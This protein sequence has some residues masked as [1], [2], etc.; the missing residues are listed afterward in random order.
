MPNLKQYLTT[1]YTIV[2][3]DISPEACAPFGYLHGEK[4]RTP[5]GV[6]ATVI[7]VELPSYNGLSYNKLWYSKDGDGGRVCHWCRGHNKKDFDA[8]GFRPLTT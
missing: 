3:L 8:E 1:G 4:F 2:G 7:G 5:N 6:A